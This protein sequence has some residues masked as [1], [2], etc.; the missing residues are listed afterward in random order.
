MAATGKQSTTGR[1]WRAGPAGFR[2]ARALLGVAAVAAGSAAVFAVAGLGAA[3]SETVVVETWRAYGLAVFAGLFALLA[4]NP[5]GYRGVWELVI[6]HKV[7]LTITALLLGSGASG[8]GQVIAWDGGLSVLVLI[9]YL[10]CRGWRSW[11]RPLVEGATPPS[12]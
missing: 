7:A 4:W 8:T 2:A 9:A 12:P 10:S 11:R 5:L 1:A 6:A 3:S